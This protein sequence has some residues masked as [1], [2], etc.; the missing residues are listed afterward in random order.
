VLNRRRG[1]DTGE[2]EEEEDE[3]RSKRKRKQQEWKER[4][5]KVKG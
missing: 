4:M 1:N 2:K 5:A 3:G